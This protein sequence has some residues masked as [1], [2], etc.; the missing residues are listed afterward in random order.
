MA[1]EW[2]FKKGPWDE[3]KFRDDTGHKYTQ[4]FVDSWFVATEG[5]VGRTIE[6]AVFS[7]SETA[8]AYHTYQIVGSGRPRND[9]L[10]RLEYRAGKA[11]GPKGTA[12]R[13][14]WLAFYVSLGEREKV[15]HLLPSPEWPHQGSV[16]LR[17]DGLVYVEVP[18]GYR[19]EPTG[20][21]SAAVKVIPLKAGFRV[22]IAD[23]STPLTEI[24]NGLRRL[25]RVAIRLP[26]LEPL[27]DT[28]TLPLSRVLAGA[29]FAE[30]LE[31]YFFRRRGTLAEEKV[32][33]AS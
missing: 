33:P 3:R 26:E 18:I 29:E 2:T 4:R 15:R 22:E 24:L 31:P 8:P 10:I 27:L 12:E 9:Q 23:R 11:H 16:D 1:V 7:D 32:P 17:G 25:S 13:N 21:A 30:M 5:E 20:T 19:L 28:T 6:V 14:Q